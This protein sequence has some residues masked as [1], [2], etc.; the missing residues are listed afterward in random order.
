M[1]ATPTLH[2]RRR[3]L[4]DEELA[5]VPWLSHLKPATIHCAIENRKSPTQAGGR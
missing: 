2:E 1:S 4:S 3:L 5:G